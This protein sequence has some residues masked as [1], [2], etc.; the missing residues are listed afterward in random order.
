MKGSLLNR[1]VLRPSGPG[2]ER[3][4]AA[5]DGD[6]EAIGRARALVA[7]FLERVRERHGEARPGVGGMA[8]LVVS[9]L[10]TNA[11]KYAPGPCLLDLAADVAA[12]ELVMSVWDSGTVLPAILPPDATRIGRHGLEIVA[13]LST[14]LEIR[15]EPVGK[16]VTIRMPLADA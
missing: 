6:S 13:A 8:Q 12:G 15:R 14:S 10:V 7:A 2:P 3:A 16:R 5:F 9:E 1:E 4:A 11:C